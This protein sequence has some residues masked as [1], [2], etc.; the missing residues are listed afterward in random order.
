MASNGY[1]LLRVGADDRR[2]DVRGYAYE[3]R[4]A[5]ESK[6]GRPVLAS[7]EVHHVDGDRANN[8]PGNLEVL[9]RSEHRV[10]HRRRAR[11]EPLRMPGEANPGIPCACGCGTVFARYDATGRPRRY[12]SGHNLHPYGGA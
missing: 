11:T 7:E 4:V 1:V 6:L 12:V 10:K 5:A 8:A 3:H 2:A 9:T